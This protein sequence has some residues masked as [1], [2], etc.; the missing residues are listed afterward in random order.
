MIKEINKKYKIN[1]EQL[2][3][4]EWVDKEKNIYLSF[5][6][7]KIKLRLLVW[8]LALTD[9]GRALRRDRSKL[10]KAVLSNLKN[11]DNII[12]EVIEENDNYILYKCSS[13][14]LVE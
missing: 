1:L 9:N 12:F 13:R 2:N 6:V 10:A 3:E 5:D 8:N 4:N 14:D 7:R 11:K